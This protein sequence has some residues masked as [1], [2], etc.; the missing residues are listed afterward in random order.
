MSNKG[1]LFATAAIS[2]LLAAPASAD[3][4][5]DYASNDAG[6]PTLTATLGTGEEGTLEWF[7]CADGGSLCEPL[8]AEAYTPTGERSRAASPGETAPGTVFE[9]VQTAPG[10][11]QTKARTVAWQGR[12][13]ATVAPGLQGQAAVGQ[14]V[15]VV[16]GTWTGGWALGRPLV[17]SWTTGVLACRE[18]T[19]GEC[20][21]IGWGTQPATIDAR[22]AGWYLLASERAFS[23]LAL[24]Q[25]ALPA[26]P[27]PWAPG[28]GSAHARSA[29][30]GPVALGEAKP[31][32]GY[33]KVGQKPK[34]T[35][36]AR[37]LRS[38]GRLTVG[39]VTCET[40]CSVGL[41]VSGGGRKAITRT[42][43]V[44][45]TQKLTIPIRRGKL[46]VRVTADG[47][48]VSSGRTRY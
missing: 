10:G 1:L 23:M 8:P 25:P 20:W 38:K 5:V 11:A 14:A 9:V 26:P 40:R 32:I 2:L 42:F 7:R 47:K 17:Q 19:G 4:F 21:L 48:L 35:I 12:I 30:L 22:W 31:P 16:P 13:G 34:A 6:D 15:T 46:N 18:P 44:Q 28:T 43:S 24:V 3:P 37:A 33:V 29:P 39:S 45:G 36:R 27:I 41:K